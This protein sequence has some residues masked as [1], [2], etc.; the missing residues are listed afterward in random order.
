MK[1]P[2]SIGTSRPSSASSDKALLQW[3]EEA[4]LP[5]DKETGLQRVDEAGIPPG[6]CGTMRPGSPNTNITAD[7][8]TN[9]N[10]Q[11]RGAERARRENVGLVGGAEAGLVSGA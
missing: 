11:Q 5:S 3:D 4:G 6:F 7:A 9:Y 2:S 8:T 1:R 10:Q